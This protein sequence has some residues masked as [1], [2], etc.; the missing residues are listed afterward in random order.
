MIEPTQIPL[1]VSVKFPV[2]ITGF[3]QSEQTEVVKHTPLFK[4]KYWDYVEEPIL[5]GEEDDDEDEVADQQANDNNKRNTHDPG[6]GADIGPVATGPIADSDLESNGF[7]SAGLRGTNSGGES[8]ESAKERRSHSPANSSSE[9]KTR[10]VKKEFFSSFEAPVKGVI[11]SFLFCVG[12]R[13][14]SS[15]QPVVSIIEPCTHS[16][17]YGGLCALCGASLDEQDYTEFNN[18]DRAPISMSHDTSGLKVSYNEAERIEKSS[19]QRLLDEKKLIL[20]VD[21]DQTVI[22]AAVDPTIGEWMR[23]EKNPNH[24]S[25]KDV[26]T[27]C[28]EETVPM[29]PRARANSP[30]KPLVNP[31]TSL[32]WYYVKLRPGLDS[33]LKSLA[34]LYEMHIYTMATKSYAKA[35]A[36]IIDPDGKYFGDRILSRD[37]SGSLLQKSLKRLFPVST[38]MVAIIDDRGDVWKWSNNLIKVVPYNFF[39]G[40]G[41]INSS[42]LPQRTGII[43][44]SMKKKRNSITAGTAPAAASTTS[45]ASNTDSVDTTDKDANTATS[46]DVSGDMDVDKS[47]T[48]NDKDSS[49][50]NSTETPTA[51][52]ESKI[53]GY[54]NGLETEADQEVEESVELSPVEQLVT[55]GGGEDNVE[56]LSV[57]ASER[58][59]SLEAQQIERPLA[60]LQ[61][62][63]DRKLHHEDS[64]STK[65][66]STTPSSSPD[67]TPNSSS[68]NDGNTDSNTPATST[69]DIEDIPSDHVLNDNDN[70]L[71]HLENAL[72]MIHT[73]F[74]SDYEAKSNT[75][76]KHRYPVDDQESTPDLSEIIPHLKSKVFD[77]CVF[78]FSGIVP[79]GRNFDT[80]D[81]VQWV[82]SFGA[83]VVADLIDSVT[84]VIA[85]SGGTFKVRM[86]A[87]HPKIKIVYSDWVYACIAAWKRVPEDEYLIEVPDPLFVSEG[88][89]ESNPQDHWIKEPVTQP[90]EAVVE[91]FRQSLTDGDIDWDEADK[92]LE[93]FMASD[94]DD[95]D[96]EDDDGDDE[97]S[98][99]DENKNE[100]IDQND[101]D[102]RH[103]NETPSKPDETVSRKHDRTDDS[104]D[105]PP[106]FKTARL[107]P[108]D[109]NRQDDDDDDGDSYDEDEFAKELE[110]DL[111]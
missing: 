96:D 41:D 105:E 34:E 25:L 43:E 19:S 54:V 44:S 102:D 50:S 5:A 84:H 83:V 97:T 91:K 59:A 36:N 58:S 8:K 13:V 33:F 100:N 108:D 90:E 66:N 77:G 4:Y 48:S 65:S 31:P 68:T 38:S 56:L 22:H 110:N 98:D 94:D 35:I 87:G 30:D 85:T 3:L 75:K 111:L 103:D 109:A 62:D 93:E 2:V 61:R 104:A 78:L 88:G 106:S 17:Q 15:H 73:K 26:R 52:G 11:D 63:L 32:C 18:T 76:L 1:P 28:L 71:E 101:N 92:E 45:S 10:R 51:D 7:D 9:Q 72:R 23:D 60:K 82:R 42:F 79:L 16:V 29:P 74:Y 24:A 55:I 81:I 12:D 80:Y 37:D 99:N 70:E 27:F 64:E 6:A 57:Q 53:K 40:I 21:L 47:T 89:E 49:D 95:D 46:Q 14:D 39:V 20:V 69:D 107:D 67:G 86:A